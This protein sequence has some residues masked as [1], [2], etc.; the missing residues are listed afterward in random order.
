L[1]EKNKPQYWEKGGKS[2]IPYRIT[3]KT[4]PC[5]NMKKKKNFRQVSGVFIV[6]VEE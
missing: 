4:A 5:L 1:P 6:E 2:K 3:S